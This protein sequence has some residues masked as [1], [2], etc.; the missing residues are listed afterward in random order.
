MPSTWSH[1][2]AET[3]FAVFFA[4]P[5]LSNQYNS[6][7]TYRGST[8]SNKASSLLTMATAPG[9]S[10]VFG[11]CTASWKWRWVPSSPGKKRENTRHKKN[12]S[13]CR[14]KG[15]SHSPVHPPFSATFPTYP[16]TC[17]FLTVRPGR[18]PLLPLAP[19]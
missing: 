5:P 11:G 10:C 16:T 14:S 19:R 12:Q 2:L 15:K 4:S 7:I 8:Y 13:A 6:P 9:I 17:P 1:P 3:T 18:L